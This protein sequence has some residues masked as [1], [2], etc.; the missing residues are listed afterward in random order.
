MI[1]KLEAEIASKQAELE[2]LNA[3]LPRLD[4]PDLKQWLRRGLEQFD[5]LLL[6]DV[7]LARQALR[8]IIDGKI[9]FTPEEGRAVR[10]SWTM[11]LDQAYAMS[12]R[13]DLA[14]PRGFEPRLPP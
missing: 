7:P 4:T 14:S 6:G 8:K 2:R 3:P 11:K 1:A 5:L 9:V 10:V 13:F 12:N